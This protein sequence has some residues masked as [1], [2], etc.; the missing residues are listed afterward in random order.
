M[1]QILVGRHAHPTDTTKRV[2]GR[3]V[4]LHRPM[5][6]GHFG[7]LRNGS[8]DAAGCITLQ[9]YVGWALGYEQ[10][11]V[12]RAELGCITLPTYVGWAFLPT[13]NKYYNEKSIHD[14]RSLQSP[15]RKR[16]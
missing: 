12:E 10:V 16:V 13:T 4:L 2:V 7:C 8:P 11:L 15:T 1:L 14:T 3:N 9:T 5:Q 6:S